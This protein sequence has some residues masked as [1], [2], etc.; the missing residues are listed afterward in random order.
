MNKSE[1]PE[2]NPASFKNPHSLKSKA[3]RLLW[4]IVYI[5]L[6]RPSPLILTGWRRWLLKLFGA[7]LGKTWVHPKV[8]IWTPWTIVM[9]DDVYIDREVNLYSTFGIE[10]GNRVVV[11]AGT[12]LCT[13]THDYQDPSYP[14]IGS[15]I[16]IEDDCWI[17][18]EAFIL[19]GIHIGRGA[20]VG[21]RA[22]V[23]KNVEPWIVVA[24]NPA[25][26]I[27]PRLLKSRDEGHT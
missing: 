20:V 5:L 17:S 8:R 6:F 16:K 25:R 24:G 1:I 27:K 11:S 14:L 21:A 9:G 26:P 23:T 10:I 3:G 12:T 15:P 22:L 7:K 4:N 13:P 2:T 19:P 18:A